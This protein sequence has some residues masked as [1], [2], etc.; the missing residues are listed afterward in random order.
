M[1]NLR[2]LEYFYYVAKYEGFTQAARRVPFPIQQPALS[3]RV[4]ALEESLRL[5]LYQ[6]VGRRF[7]LTPSGEYL[8]QALMPFFESLDSV[9]RD[10]KGEA[11]GRLVVAEAAPML[12][13]NR[14]RSALVTFRRRYPGVQLSILERSW[15]DLL[16]SVSAGE[17]DLA[18]G[19]APELRG[20]LSFEEWAEAGYLLLCPARH[21][22]LRNP[23]ISLADLAAHPL[24]LLE[25]RTAD[26]RHIEDTFS[27]ANAPIEVALETSSYAL[28]N[29]AVARGVGVAVVNALWPR[30]GGRVRWREVDVTRLFGKKRI[31]L[32]R[33]TDKYLPPY[34]LEYL[35]LLRGSLSSPEGGGGPE[36]G[37][38]KP[39]RASL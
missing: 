21:P 2:Q 6:I 37:G 13:L 11:H 22:L 1:M 27:R 25:G 10:L 5:K 23:E 39:A 18:F 34:A 33:R 26:R 35:A 7:Q 32:F 12:I 31:G 28:I 20:S 15:T 17:V 16:E 8:Y 24:V 14:R 29:E 3:I 36:R 19:S 4:K 9:E 30:P 38:E